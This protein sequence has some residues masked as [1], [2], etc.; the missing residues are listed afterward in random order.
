MGKESPVRIRLNTQ[1]IDGRNSVY[2]Y[3]TN[4][5][6]SKLTIFVHSMTDVKTCEQ[7]K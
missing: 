4:E 5:S 6:E 1:W 3:V 2:T 7:I